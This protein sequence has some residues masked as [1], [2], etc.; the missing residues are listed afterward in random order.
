MRAAGQWVG[1]RLPQRFGVENECPVVVAD[2]SRFAALG[3]CSAVAGDS[4]WD[5][6]FAGARFSSGES[7]WAVEQHSAV[8]LTG[9]I[10]P[11]G[12][13][14]LLAT[15]IW[16]RVAVV[17]AKLLSECVGML[18]ATIQ[19]FAHWPRLTYR[20]P[21]PPAW[22][23]LFFAALVALAIAARTAA[24]RKKA[25]GAMRRLPGPITVGEW[26]SAIAVAAFALRH[27]DLPVCAEVAARE[28]RSERI[29]CGS[30]RFDFRG[31]ARRAT[32]C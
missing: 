23:V 4:S 2:P 10:V 13:L 30:G 9:V 20:I 8:I 26:V 7:G 6:A 18:L 32:R 28:I 3:N 27:R 16:S 19:W 14:A 11:L 24:M 31:F 1:A 21:G 15:F 29:R 5:V 25:P 12:F 17:L 22:L